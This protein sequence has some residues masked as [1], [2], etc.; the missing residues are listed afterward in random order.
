MLNCKN[1]LNV[2]TTVS[3]GTNIVSGVVFFYFFIYVFY[4][5]GD[6]ENQH[7]ALLMII[8]GIIFMA[9]EVVQDGELMLL[10]DWS[11]LVYTSY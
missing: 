1:K 7:A 6:S 2:I 4:F 8:L 3:N 5:R 10:A 11:L 9:G